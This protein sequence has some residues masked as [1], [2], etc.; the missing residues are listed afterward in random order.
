MLHHNAIVAQPIPKTDKVLITTGY[1]VPKTPETAGSVMKSHYNGKEG[2]GGE[3]FARYEG[4][5]ATDSAMQNYFDQFERQIKAA[6]AGVVTHE[7][8]QTKTE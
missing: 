4:A 2:R 7:M 8:T 3:E 5:P 1:K 6:P